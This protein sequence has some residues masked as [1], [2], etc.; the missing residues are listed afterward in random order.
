M[1]KKQR[2]FPLLLAILL[3]VPLLGGASASEASESETSAPVGEAFS[4][5]EYVLNRDD[6]YYHFSSITDVQIRGYIGGD[7]IGFSYAPKVSAT[8]DGN[9]RFAATA[10]EVTGDVARSITV[11]CGEA[12]LAASSK[13]VYFI[14]DSLYFSGST[15]DL[16]AE[17]LEVSLSGRV[18]G[19]VNVQADRVTFLNGFSCTGSIRVTAKEV[20]FGPVDAAVV[21][22]QQV[23]T[24]SEIGGQLLE[25]LY[26]IPAQI[27]IV[28]LLLFLLRKPFGSLCAGF[29]RDKVKI[30]L[31]GLAGLFIPILAIFLLLTMIGMPV[32]LLLL[33]GYFF[34]FFICEPIAA[35]L[36]AGA[37]INME[38]NILRPRSSSPALCCS[39]SCRFFRRP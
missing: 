29:N 12:T 7:L 9:L 37:Y 35:I 25:L 34:L 1:M 38:T 20:E 13:S 3:F 23:T 2:L 19:D 4:T 10:L 27:L 31:T 36:I 15:G 32:S 11:A 26:S 8:I 17:A 22:W 5:T 39:S 14:G 24:G 6:D 18:D 33:A 21:E 30:A 28:L 16:T